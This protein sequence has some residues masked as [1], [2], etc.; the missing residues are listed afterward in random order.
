MATATAAM[1][2]RRAFTLITLELRRQQFE[3]RLLAGGERLVRSGRLH[4]WA[5]FAL[6]EPGDHAGLD[7]IGNMARL[8]RDFGL[9]VLQ[10]AVSAGHEVLGPVPAEALPRA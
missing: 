5:V 9:S 6:V 1:R 8:D 7:R 2:P 10:D 4:E 3:C